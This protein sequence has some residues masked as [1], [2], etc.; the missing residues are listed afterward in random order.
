MPRIDLDNVDPFGIV[1]SLDIKVSKFPLID[2]ISK[3]QS[4]ELKLSNNSSNHLS[5]PI[6]KL[7]T[8][9]NFKPA[10]S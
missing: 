2:Q 6:F 8:S 10:N 7:S 3:F 9:L 5:E 4:F 1:E